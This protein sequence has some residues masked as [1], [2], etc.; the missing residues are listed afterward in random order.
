MADQKTPEPGE[1]GN[2]NQPGN[3]GDRPEA[4]AGRRVE[5]GRAPEPGTSQGRDE[6]LGPAGTVSPGMGSHGDEQAGRT[7]GADPDASQVPPPPSA[8]AGSHLQAQ[9]YGESS[10]PIATDDT[11]G[12]EAMT[13]SAGAAGNADPGS[14]TPGEVEGVSA[15]TEDAATGTSENAAPVVGARTATAEGDAD[16]PGTDVGHGA[17]GGAVGGSSPAGSGGSAGQPGSGSPAAAHGE[18]PGAASEQSPGEEPR[19]RAD[20][21]PVTGAHRPSAPSGEVSPT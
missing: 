16:A 20:E 1:P 6:P 10:D 17:G 19:R 4:G 11:R 2:E 5:P 18:D 9:R 14:G 15:N 3:A 7:T 8:P 13:R 12:I 21:R